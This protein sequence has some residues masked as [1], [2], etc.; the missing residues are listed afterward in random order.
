M[1]NVASKNMRAEKGRFAFSVAGVAVAALLLSFMLALYSGWN[2]RIAS[3]VEDVPADIWLS[4]EGNESFFSQ[5]LIAEDRIRE[6]AGVD[7]VESISM[8]LGRGLKVSAGGDTYDS[9]VVGYEPGGAGGPIDIK[10]GADSPAD[11][12]III[13]RVLART[14]GI[15]VGD[16]ITVGDRPLTVAGISTGGNMVIYQLSF[17]S[18]NTARELVGLS[19]YATFA[20]IDAAGDAG[21]VVARINNEHDGV[22]AHERAEFADSSR[23]VLR[24]SMLPI[25]S[26]LIVLIFIVGAVVVG[27]TIYTATLEKEREYGV[28]KALGTPNKQLLAVVAQQTIV[29]CLLGFVAGEV[30]VLFASRLAE[31]AVP[32]FVTLIRWEDAVIVLIGTIIM[33]MIGAYLP[34]QRILRVDPL[35]VFK[36]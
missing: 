21:D 26:V 13:D 8:L 2:E 27:V 20:L 19:G 31:R 11:G 3:Y 6:V 36:A 28:M 16:E 1:I 4:Q 18:L 35:R 34:V 7:G 9:Y 33:G 22:T 23:K 17:V 15:D 29:C 25:L 14:A 12:E 5:S 10:E 30:A 32:Q 24:R